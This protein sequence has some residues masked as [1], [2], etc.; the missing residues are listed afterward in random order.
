MT[1]HS[2]EQYV[3]PATTSSVWQP[4]RKMGKQA[5]DCW[6][7]PWSMHALSCGT[8]RGAL[9][10]RA[11]MRLEGSV[12][13]LGERHQ[14]ECR[15]NA[16]RPLA[17]LRPARHGRVLGAGRLLL[18]T[19]RV[20]QKGG[21]FPHRRRLRA[22]V[23]RRPCWWRS[24]LIGEV[25]GVQPASGQATE[26][27]RGAFE[28]GVGIAA[29]D[30]RRDRRRL[31]RLGAA[32]AQAP[33]AVVDAATVAGL[34]DADCSV[35]HAVTQEEEAAHGPQPPQGGAG[36]HG[37]IAAAA[38]RGDER[39]G[40]GE[41]QG[42]K[43]VAKCIWQD[44][45]ELC[46]DDQERAQPGSYDEV[47]DTHDADRA[48]VGGEEGEGEEVDARRERPTK[49][50]TAGVR[51]ITSRAHPVCTIA[52]LTRSRRPAADSRAAC[53]TPLTVAELAAPEVVLRAA[54]IADCVR[55]VAA[56]WT[57]TLDSAFAPRRSRCR[58]A[59]SRSSRVGSRAMAMA[60][61][62]A[63]SHLVPPD[64]RQT[65]PRRCRGRTGKRK[66]TGSSAGSSR[67]R[68]LDHATARSWREE[69]RS[70]LGSRQTRSARPFA[71]Y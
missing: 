31:L 35:E 18:I 15:L 44:S 50:M 58:P 30:E 47:S 4:A 42:S 55:E 23:E 56:P 28:R 70:P 6:M 60:V 29:T 11:C 43:W 59:R 21:H 63:I 38:Q 14:P 65:R 69:T 64:R 19:P 13:R 49:A 54:A 25:R 51:L 32:P 22:R 37:A 12:Q 1:H 3:G 33:Q 20:A 48:C 34:C 36:L 27:F 66:A 9:I 2:R 26:E 62:K 7:L 61:V 53:N 52:K 57:P 39:A 17:P 10:Y 45:S 68:T 40:G 24:R 41:E 71:S 8:R 16:G 46:S 67:R 5:S